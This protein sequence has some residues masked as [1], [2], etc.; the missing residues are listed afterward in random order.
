MLPG[1]LLLPLALPL[2]WEAGQQE[3]RPSLAWAGEGCIFPFRAKPVRDL[4]PRQGA[5]STR[6]EGL[7]RVR[8]GRLGCELPSALPASPP[9]APGGWPL[10]QEDRACLGMSSL[11]PTAFPNP[12]RLP[13]SA[14]IA[15]PN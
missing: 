9:L 12:I 15:P 2:R 7:E 8:E 6:G 10:A 13:G 11:L 1:R 5:L 4:R 3:A 14:Q